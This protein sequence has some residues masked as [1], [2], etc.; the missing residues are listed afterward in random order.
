MGGVL[1]LY[2]GMDEAAKAARAARM[3]QMQE[4]SSPQNESPKD[5]SEIHAYPASISQFVRP[6]KYSMLAFTWA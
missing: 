5:G 2:G 1:R 6:G 3:K 4:K